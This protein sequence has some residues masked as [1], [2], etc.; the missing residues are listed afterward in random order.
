MSS[1]KASSVGVNVGNSSFTFV[2]HSYFVFSSRR[3]S[4]RRHPCIVLSVKHCA[5]LIYVRQ[6]EVC[7]TKCQFECPNRLL[8]NCSKDY[9]R[10]A[11]VVFDSV[12]VFLDVRD[13]DWSDIL[14]IR[15][16]LAE[17]VPSAQRE[18]KYFS[19]ACITFCFYGVSC[20]VN[21]L[22]FLFVCLFFPVL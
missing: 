22:V 5:I 4:G 10:N 19:I 20:S 15:K 14:F 2:C 21:F 17:S 8:N 9:S 11:V 13:N 12:F 6:N 16:D 1:G 18:E 3:K 7:Q